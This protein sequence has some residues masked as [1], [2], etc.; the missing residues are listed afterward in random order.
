MTHNDTLVGP[1]G[2]SCYDANHVKWPYGSTAN[3]LTNGQPVLII[4]EP[5]A[6]ICFGLTWK[7]GHF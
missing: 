1:N 3:L 2:V 6:L 7:I 4:R 5:N